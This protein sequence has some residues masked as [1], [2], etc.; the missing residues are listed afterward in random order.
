MTVEEDIRRID[1]DITKLKIQF[2]LYFAGSVP[3]PPTSQRDALEKQVKQLQFSIKSVADRFLYNAVLNKF[4]AYS[5]LWLKNLRIKEEGVHLHPLARRAAHHAAAAAG[6]T[7]G[8]NGSAAVG[9]AAAA[10]ARQGPGRRSAAK[11][12]APHPDSWRI[13]TT[14]NDEKALRNLYENF[15]AAKDQV[16]DQKKPS[17]D[18]F[19]REIARH[20]ATIKDKVDCELIDFRIYSREKKVSIKAKPL[21]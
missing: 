19:A 18:T 4:N 7:G 12:H 5:E 10:A 21:K 6:V 8:S 2:D 20:T 13:S 1:V 14:R 16:G 9:A 15:I 17:F 11:A 3:R